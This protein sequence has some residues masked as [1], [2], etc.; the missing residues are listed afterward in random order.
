MTSCS[1]VWCD[2]YLEFVELN[3]NHSQSFSTKNNKSSQQCRLLFEGLIS[4]DSSASQ[5]L[6]ANLLDR[7]LILPL[8]LMRSNWS[9]VPSYSWICQFT[10]RS[11]C[12]RQYWLLLSGGRE[13]PTFVSLKIS[14]PERYNGVERAYSYGRTTCGCDS[15]WVLVVV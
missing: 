13:I 8:R 1:C 15:W 4:C 10:S 6:F 7:E 5:T 12:K 2:I 14:Q 3:V 9:L 11:G